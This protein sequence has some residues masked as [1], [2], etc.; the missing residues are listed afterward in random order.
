ATAPVFQWQTRSDDQANWIDMPGERDEELT[1]MPI[2]NQ[3]YRLTAAASATNL[4]EPLCRISSE[5]V[6][7]AQLAPQTDATGT[8]TMD[9]I[10]EN[11]SILLDPPE[12][13]GAN[14]GPLTYQWQLDDGGGREDI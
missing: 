14:V 1:V 7:I 11:G 8:S 6:R 12:H 5:P 9:P 2:H 3:W 4:D 10:C 13:I